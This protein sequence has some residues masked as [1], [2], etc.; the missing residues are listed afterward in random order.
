VEIGESGG[1]GGG[2]GGSG[3]D[4]NGNVGQDSLIA[5]GDGLECLKYY[6][7]NRVVLARWRRRS[8]CD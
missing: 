5:G 4:S 8:R 6:Y 2:G 7:A 3:S 1:S